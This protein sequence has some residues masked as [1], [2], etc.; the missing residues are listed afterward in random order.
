MSYKKL[1]IV[2]LKN[3]VPLSTL[4]LIATLILLVLLLHNHFQL[5]TATVPLD[6]YEATMPAV[7]SVI[8]EGKNPY[9]FE[10]QPSNADVYTPLYNI[11]VAPFAIVLG[12][13]LQLHRF[14]AGIFIILSCLLCYF[15]TLKGSRSRIDSMAAAVTLYA[16]LL[17]YSTPVASTNS[18]GT[19]LF[20]SSLL[21]PW[22]YA[23]TNRS[24]AVGL[25]CGLLA[26]YTKQY[27]VAGLGFLSLYL[28][29]AVSVKRAFVFG[30][31]STIGFISSLIIV[32][33]TSPYF[34]DNTVFAGKALTGMIASTDSVIKQI[35]FFGEVYS[36]L[37]IL[38]LIGAGHTIW[39]RTRSISKTASTNP[40]LSIN[41]KVLDKPLF[42][43]KPD[44]HWFCFACSTV[45]IVLILGRN[46]GN[47]MTYLFQLMSPFLLIAGF[48]FIAKSN[49]PKVILLPFIFYCFF[50]T[51][52]ILPKDFS[53]S[54][55]HT[56]NWNKLNTMIKASDHV[57]TSPVLLMPIVNSGKKIYQNGHSR[58]F[59][60]ASTKPEFLRKTE[61][62]MRV[63]SIMQNHIN[64]IYTNI[65][66]QKFDLIIL[67]HWT[68]IPGLPFQPNLGKT[69][70]EKFYELRASLPISLVKRRGGGPK[71][72]Q[73]WQPKKL[74]PQ[75]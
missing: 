48:T 37:L 23:F 61:E 24:L 10:L 32:H 25:I 7:T 13:T 2:S 54:S 55:I 51:Y 11:I 6:Y 20:L 5:I 59:G 46:P 34:L 44:Y 50:Q 19:F 21:I 74:K 38:L 40:K 15:A 75:P 56:T 35:T 69:Y 31:L 49:Y 36:S 72:M 27:F 8:A 73:V 30:F 67:D 4:Y 3:W 57:F 29:V 39:K 62:K 63:G 42:N 22:M 53:I 60:F 45:V 71:V 12:N 1:T 33:L 68:H 28:F 41:I 64:N 18:V 14:V 16:A 26:F 65:K 52:S 17:F 70:L 43:K 58:F 66:T 9:T 47:Y